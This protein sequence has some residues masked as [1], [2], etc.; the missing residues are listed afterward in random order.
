MTTFPN[1]KVSST[2]AG[3]LVLICLFPGVSPA[4]TTEPGNRRGLL[5]KYTSHWGMRLKEMVTLKSW[6]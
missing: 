5:N 4:S 1:K 2:K 6:D 3:G